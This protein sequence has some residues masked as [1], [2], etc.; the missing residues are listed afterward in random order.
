M[1]T[2]VLDQGIKAKGLKV[3]LPRMKVMAVLTAEKDTPHMTAEE[4]Y[5][6]LSSMGEEVSLPTVYRVLA[7]FESAGL[8]K[9]HCFDGDKAVYEIDDGELH[10]HMVCVCCS[11]VIEFTDVSIEDKLYHVAKA[12]QFSLSD[13]TIL[14]H[15][16]CVRCSQ[17]V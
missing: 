5:N 14:L 1:D 15:G 12:N 8:V 6:R 10:N 17:A 16:V 7:Q 9:R 11:T 4:V 2:E 13:Y 3:T